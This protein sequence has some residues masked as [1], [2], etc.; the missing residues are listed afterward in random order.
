MKQCAAQLAVIRFRYGEV[1]IAN[2]AGV[3]KGRSIQL[4]Q[5]RNVG[6][7]EETQFCFCFPRGIAQGEQTAFYMVAVS[8]AKHD[9]VTVQCENELIF[10]ASCAEIVEIAVADHLC[11]RQQGI[12]FLQRF[13]IPKMVSEMDDLIRLRALHSQL[14]IPDITVR[15][16]EDQNSHG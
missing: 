4:F 7:S 5:V 12:G 3:E 16:G 10:P 11:N 15:I 1:P 2:A 9:A 13:T 8:V 14:H 6:V